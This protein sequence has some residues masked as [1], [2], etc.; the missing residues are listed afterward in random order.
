[1]EIIYCSKC[2]QPFAD[3]AFHVTT[4]SGRIYCEVCIFQAMIDRRSEK[5][6]G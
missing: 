4:A 2:K 5:K 6:T 3:T 1:M